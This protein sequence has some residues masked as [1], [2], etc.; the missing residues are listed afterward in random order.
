MSRR[1]ASVTALAAAGLALGCDGAAGPG[2]GDD[3]CALVAWYRPSAAA[4]GGVALDEAARP[5]LVGSWEGWQRPGRL[6]WEAE[7]GGDWLR[8]AQALP[9]GVHQYA[10][11][12]GDALLLDE[13]NARTSFL[14]APVGDGG[15][16]WGT[17]VS[18]IEV[19]D[20]ARTEIAFAS[21]S[22]SSG[23][24]SAEAV[25]T[26]ASLDPARLLATLRRGAETLAAPSVI[27]GAT[28][29][30]GLHL[31]L[32]ASGLAPGKYTLTLALADG[33]A[34]AGAS[35]FVEAEPAPRPLDDGL[36]YQIVIDRFRGPAGALGPPPTPG[37][38][39]GGTLDGV[40]AA[41]EAGYFQRL[42]VTTLWLSPLYTNP[43]G[44]FVGRDGHLYEAYHGYWPS[45][46]R[47]VEPLLGGA[48]A[49]DALVAAAHA[50]GVR[51]IADAVPNH[52]HDSHPY[53]QQHSLRAASVGGAPDPR[54]VDWYNDGPGACV[55]GTDGCPWDETCWF[56]HY[57][58]DVN[59]RQ[60][61]ARAA[62]AADLAWW[63]TRFDLDG[64]RLDA[65]PMMPRAATR[66]IDRAARSTALRQGLDGLLLGEIYTG[67]GDGGRDEIRAYLSPSF[68]GLDS[69]FDFPLLWATRDVIAHGTRSFADLEEEVAAS[70]RAW[71]GAGVTMAHIVGNH[72]TNRFL[73]EAAGDGDGDPWTAPPPQP[74]T[75]EP[76]RRLRLAL[77]FTLTLPGLPV[78]YYGDEAG[79]AG[80]GDP[81][82]R[83]VLPDVLAPLPPRQAD[84]L[85]EVSRIGRLR[86]CMP[87][88]RRGARTVLFADGD[89]DVALRSLDGAAPALVVLSRD[90]AAAQLAIAGAPAGRY[91]DALSTAVLVV[92]PDGSATIAA[93]PLATS[94]YV[95]DTDPC[96]N[97]N[98]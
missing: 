50:R 7:P 98:P 60:P 35:A 57:L 5:A 92:A 6:D 26:P 78:I 75:D 24:L 68:D 41:L 83:R 97:D 93:P 4:A 22:A 63:L 69:A 56:D 25:V 29:G 16:P 51:V 79:L 43:S 33:S 38:R 30:Q 10:I 1:S 86:A 46:P 48:A 96:L 36:L 84:V 77:A 89:H 12:A 19:P 80:A 13:G 59:W 52:T 85:A 37:E 62:G 71:A 90:R 40:R 45:Q 94:I 44:K 39:A 20:C 11:A 28:D 82:S 49:L 32:A 64:L 55:C 91:R 73:S 21:V 70:E 3:R 17:E 88:L 14:A 18:E 9:P 2:P 34:S 23:A 72:D 66:A 67:P 42:G 87:A 81:D 74:L 15:V 58:P 53:F 76:Y 95:P 65:V 8:I 47:E 61:D 54:L 27:A 31:A